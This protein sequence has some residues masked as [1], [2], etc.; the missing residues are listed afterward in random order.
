MNIHGEID[1]GVF[2]KKENENH[3]LRLAGGSWSI[4]LSELSDKDYQTIVYETHE[5]RYT[6]TKE[7]AFIQGFI[8]NFQGELKLIVPIKYWHKDRN[9]E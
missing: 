3:L 1:Q 8:K 7:E 5:H 9:N 6:I 4:N 2:Y